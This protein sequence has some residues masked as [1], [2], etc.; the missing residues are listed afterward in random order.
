L[1]RNAEAY[2]IDR[3]R[4]VV[5]GHSAGAH[6]TAMMLAA[7]WPEYADDLP[8]DL[9]RGGALLSGVYDLEPLTHADHVNVDLQLKTEH[10]G[11]LS[12]AFMP[13]ASAAPVVTA[14]GGLESEEFHRQ[15]ALIAANW[16]KDLVADVPLPDRNHMTICDALAT[17]GDALFEAVKGLIGGL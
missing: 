3:N 4:I 8:A 5:A 16:K 10:I 1:W 15:N 17:K 11:P 7:R 9:V 6:L 2:D 13:K 12:P 14:V